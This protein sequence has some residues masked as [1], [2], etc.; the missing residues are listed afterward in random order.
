ME[1]LTLE[2][3]PKAFS[4]LANE[5]REIKVILQE[6]RP[7]AY[8]EKDELLTVNDAAKFLHLSIPTIYGLIHKGDLPVMKRSKRCYFSR[9]EL[10]DYIKQ[11]RKK[12]LSEINGEVD[13]YLSKQKKGG[14][15]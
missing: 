15:K 5:I 3:L 1:D 11:G 8:P 14:K 13:N 7:E 4:L 6:R 9:I 10:L 2:T 12:T